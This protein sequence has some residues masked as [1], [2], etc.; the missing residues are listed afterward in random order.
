MM[1]VLKRLFEDGFAVIADCAF[2][3]REYIHPKKG[4]FGRD[5][6]N[7]KGDVRQVGSDVRNVIRRHEQSYKPTFRQ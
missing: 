7:L 6:E 3:Q 4:G 2:D 5:R 1:G